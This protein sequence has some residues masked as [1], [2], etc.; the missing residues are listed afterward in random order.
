METSPVLTLFGNY[1]ATTENSTAVVTSDGV[2]V[3]NDI[4]ALTLS[5]S[6]GVGAKVFRY[7]TGMGQIDK[8]VYTLEP[9][10]DKLEAEA[11]R[12]GKAFNAQIV[13]Q[14]R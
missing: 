7:M 3:A 13:A 1:A 12:A 14:L 4:G 9:D 8:K 11:V 5:E 2:F 10:W 6:T